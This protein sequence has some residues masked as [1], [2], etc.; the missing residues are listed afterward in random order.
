MEVNLL[1]YIAGCLLLILFFAA[2]EV[3]F[4]SADRLSVE[5]KKKQGSFSGGIIGRFFDKPAEFIGTGLIGINISLVIYVL[6]I[7]RLTELWLPYLP[8]SFRLFYVKLIMDA[9]IAVFIILIAAQLL[10]NNLFRKRSGAVLAIAALPMLLMRLIL[11]P[12]ARLFIGISAFVLKYLFNVRIKNDKEVFTRVNMD[13][14]V[15][16]TLY[17]HDA[18]SDDKNTELFENALG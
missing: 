12:I 14:F 18:E 13:S 3:A 11:Y 5:L 4:A 9:L 7:S 10:P 2:S 8:A 16:Q 15:K 1:L 6:L 17:G